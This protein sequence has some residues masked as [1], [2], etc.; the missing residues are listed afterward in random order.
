L[1]PGSISADEVF[2]THTIFGQP[3]RAPKHAYLQ[4]AEAEGNRT[5]VTEVLGHNG[6]EASDSS[7]LL[8]PLTCT[9]APELP[10][11]RITG[12]AP[13]SAGIPD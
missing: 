8:A 3:T 9:N 12:T 5:P 13:V 2:G 1:N 6:F 11:R 4:V 7:I 10:E